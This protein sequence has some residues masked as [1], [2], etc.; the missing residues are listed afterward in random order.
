MSQF[1]FKNLN[2]SQFS[3]KNSINF[4]V[5]RILIQTNRRKAKKMAYK[6]GDLILKS[7]AFVYALDK[8]YQKEYCDF[9]L[10]TDSES[11]PLKIC[12]GCGFVRYCQKSCQIQ[13]WNEFHKTECKALKNLG[14]EARLTILNCDSDIFI[15]ICFRT[16]IKLKNGG[17]EIFEEL[18]KPDGRKIYYEN[19]KREENTE[20]VA[21]KRFAVS[22]KRHLHLYVCLMFNC[23]LLITIFSG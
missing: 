18:P 13:G 1:F 7:K 23:L 21:D 14:V 9:C 12:S 17:D 11:K 10:E 5:Q 8:N 22:V 4:K 16:L 15:R 3:S 2:I 6:P 20:L 19:L